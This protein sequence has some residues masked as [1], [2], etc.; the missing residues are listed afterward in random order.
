ML[1][2]RS[3]SCIVALR[4]GTPRPSCSDR[5]HQG[6]AVGKAPIFQRQLKYIGLDYHQKY[7]PVTINTLLRGGSKTAQF[8]NLTSDYLSWYLYSYAGAVTQ[9]GLCC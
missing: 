9:L 1:S 2:F 5:F 6:T 7:Y 3:A 8:P 4:A